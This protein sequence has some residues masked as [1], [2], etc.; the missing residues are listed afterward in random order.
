MAMRSAFRFD[1]YVHTFF[2]LLNDRKRA[3]RSLQHSRQFCFDK[4]SLFFRITHVPERRTHIKRSANLTLEQDIITAQ[5]NFGSLAGS[6]QL[7]QVTITKFVLL[8]AFIA[9]GLRIS[10]ALGDGWCCSY[11]C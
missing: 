3:A 10:D 1:D 2:I 8:V 7:L 9:D 5:M 6:L 11:R 4:P